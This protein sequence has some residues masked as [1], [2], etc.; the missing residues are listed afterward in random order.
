MNIYHLMVHA[1]EVE[2]I[3][4]RRKNKEA[5]RVKSYDGCASKGMLEIQDKSILNKRFFNQ[6]PSKF[7]TTS[8]DRVYNP[9]SRKGRGT[10]SPN[11]KITC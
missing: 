8:Y 6:V 4:L 3:R 7:V 11:K 2:E 10:S 5:K 1:Q 9:K